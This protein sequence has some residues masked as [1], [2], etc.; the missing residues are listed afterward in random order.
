MLEAAKW[1]LVAGSLV[2]TV[3]NVRKRW[4]G[5]LIWTV[6]DAGW[7][8]MNVWHRSWSEAA[9]WATFTGLSAW[10][11]VAW[12]RRKTGKNEKCK[13]QIEK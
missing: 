13:V 9:L 3:A 4:W 5:F 7:V 10:G 6:A 11:M 2:G 12:R 1:M 8:A